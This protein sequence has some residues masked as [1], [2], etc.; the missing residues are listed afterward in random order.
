MLVDY[1]RDVLVA[2]GRDRATLKNAKVRG[3]LPM[4]IGDSF[5]HEVIAP[6]ALRMLLFGL[7][8]VL[9]MLSR[10]AGLWPAGAANGR[11]PQ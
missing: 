7:S 2:K 6:G 9:I 4:C 8:M 10:P 3:K 1:D 5:G 11:R